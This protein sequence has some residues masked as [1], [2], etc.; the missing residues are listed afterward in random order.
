MSLGYSSIIF[1]FFND[2]AT[3]EI[4]TLSLHDA[5]PISLHLA[6]IRAEGER[7]THYMSPLVAQHC[8]SATGIPGKTSVDV[9]RAHRLLV[10]DAADGFREQLR[11]RQL[12][13]TAGPP[14]FCAHRD[15]VPYDQPIQRP[16]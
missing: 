12:A 7:N 8:R 15:R 4:Y 2:T 3:T 1:F 11:H 10:A 5:L 13:D 14:G 16:L 9:Q 6:D